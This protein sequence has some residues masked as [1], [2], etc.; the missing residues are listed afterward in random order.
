MRLAPE[1]RRNRAPPASHRSASTRV[2][3]AIAARGCPA[4]RPVPDPGFERDEQRAQRRAGAVRVARIDART[5]ARIGSGAAAMLRPG[6][7]VDPRSRR[8]FGVLPA[9]RIGV[10]QR[11]ALLP[12]FGRGVDLDHQGIGRPALQQR[13]ALAGKRVGRHCVAER[14]PVLRIE[15]V[16]VLGRGPARHREAVIGEGLARARDMGQHAV[17]DAPAMC[18]RRSSRVRENAAETGRSATPRK[19]A[20]A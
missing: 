1:A 8:Q 12:I 20:H 15:P 14:K 5:G 19:P 6:D 18:R 11:G 7:H 4:A 9:G 17:E 13:A 16:L 3:S 10:N 2:P